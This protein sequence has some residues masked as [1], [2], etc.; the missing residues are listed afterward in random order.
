MVWP[1][2]RYVGHIPYVIEGNLNGST[3]L[4]FLPTQ[5]PLLLEEIPLTRRLN[6]WL[7]HDGAPP[8]SAGL[9]MERKTD[10][11]KIIADNGP[12]H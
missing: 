12:V 2:E 7:Q 1:R 11:T 9:V 4:E 3:Y 5:L 8:H 10:G 6:F